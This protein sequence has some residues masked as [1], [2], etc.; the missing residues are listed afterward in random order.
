MKREWN[1]IIASN[2]NILGGVEGKGDVHEKRGGTSE[3]D[4]R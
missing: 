1:K 2:A 3:V 4:A